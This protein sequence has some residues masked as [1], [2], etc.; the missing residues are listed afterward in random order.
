MRRRVTSGAL[1]YSANKALNA[2][3]GLREAL[4]SAKALKTSFE[5]L[6]IPAHVHDRALST[7]VPDLSR[8]L[9]RRVIGMGGV[10][11]HGKRLLWQTA[12]RF[13]N[14]TPL[15]DVTSLLDC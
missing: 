11:R 10:L 7:L 6:G 14:L 12:D 5:G 15:T 8:T 13:G 4:T 3:Y 9:A 1:L 2:G